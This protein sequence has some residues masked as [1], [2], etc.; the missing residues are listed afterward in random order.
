MGC[1][2][3]VLFFFV[4]PILWCSWRWLSQIWLWIKMKVKFLKCSSILVAAYW[5]LIQNSADLKK[6]FWNLATTKT[7]KFIVLPF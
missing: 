1:S 3:S 6:N 2:Q 5:N 4:F 7:Q